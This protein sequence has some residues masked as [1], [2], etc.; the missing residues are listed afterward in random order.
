MGLMGR[1]LRSQEDCKERRCQI[2]K[3]AI[4]GVL[5]RTMG[6]QASNAIMLLEFSST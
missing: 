3:R 1:K 2:S 6:S 4:Q 5:D